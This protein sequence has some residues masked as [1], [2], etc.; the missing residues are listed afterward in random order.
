[1]NSVEILKNIEMRLTNIEG[2]LVD[3]LDLLSPPSEL[4]EDGET[5]KTTDSGRLMTENNNF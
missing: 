2:R 3:I 1:M 4:P 5:S